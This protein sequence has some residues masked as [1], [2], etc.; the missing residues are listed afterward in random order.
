MTNFK[1]RLQRLVIVVFSFLIYFPINVRIKNAE[2]AFF[3]V[4]IE[5]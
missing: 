5:Y 3:W 1:G 4:K 2:L